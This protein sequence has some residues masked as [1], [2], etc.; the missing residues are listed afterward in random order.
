[1]KGKSFYR[2]LGAIRRGGERD[3]KKGSTKGGNFV[4]LH[5]FEGRETK[6]YA[7]RNLT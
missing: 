3:A 5:D 6:G 7:D 2:F 1:M 4:C